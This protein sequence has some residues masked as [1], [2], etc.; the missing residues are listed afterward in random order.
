MSTER[1]IETSHAAIAVRI[2]QGSGL[3]VVLLHGNS[4]SKEAF[5]HQMDGTPG[6]QYQLVAVDLPGHGASG[7]ARDP[8]RTYSIPGYADAVLEVLAE[9]GLK[10]A[11]V[12]G[13]SL[14]GHVGIDMIQ[15]FPGMA[16]LM[17]SGTPPVRATPESVMG[18]FKPN[19]AVALFGQE[20]LSAEEMDIFARGVYGAAD[21]PV[22]RD[23]LARTDGQARRLMIESLFT[24]HTADQ[25]Q[26]VETTD[27]P[28]AIV[29]GERDPFVN[30]DYIAG[31]AIPSLWE[32]HCFI[33]R[34]AG[35]AAFLTHPDRFNPIFER[36]VADVATR[37][38]RRRGSKSSKGAAAA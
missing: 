8:L 1:T 12:F 18:G 13:W 9:L 11:A 20:R 31:L 14:G 19:P 22:F 33:L 28:L 5:R 25:R 26:I 27:V 3:P 10:R 30:L 2:S 29:D 38:S 35:H 21:A 17:I 24:G 15:R 34:E 4:G 32:K 36:F 37:T 23:A 6:E 7:N 16:G